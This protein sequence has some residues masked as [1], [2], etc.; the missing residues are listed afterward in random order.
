MVDVAANFGD[1]HAKAVGRRHA[2]DGTRPLHAIEAVVVRLTSPILLHSDDE[3]AA[4]VRGGG[5]R[6]V[7]HEQHL[8]LGE[9]DEGIDSRV[10]DERIT[11][12]VGD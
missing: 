1:G 12:S 3:L 6:T 2:V 9:V 10:A 4:E 11:S 7:S 5:E 8:A